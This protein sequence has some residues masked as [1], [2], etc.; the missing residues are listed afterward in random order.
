MARLDRLAPVR[1][2]AQIGAC[3]GREF[4]HE[5]LAAVAPMTGNVLTDALQQLIGS[6]LIFAVGTPPE[7]TYRFK[8]ALVQDTA[9]ESLLRRRRCELNLKI[10]ETL[11]N[12]EGTEPAI[13]AAHYTK[14]EMPNLAVP[15]WLEAGQ[16]AQA[17]AQYAES[18]AHVEAGLA[19][20][21]G[22]GSNDEKLVLEI[23]LHTCLALNYV[24]TRGYGSPEAEVSY[25]RAEALLPE[26]E[27]DRIALPVLL[28]VGIFWWLRADFPL[29][30]KYFQDLRQRA[31][32]VD[33]D[34]MVFAARAEI[35]S[36]QLYIGAPA[37]ARKLIA[38]VLR[39]YDPATHGKLSSFAMQDYAVLTAGFGAWTEN[40][41]G[42]FDSARALAGRS[43]AIARESRHA[44]SLGMALSTAACAAIERKE[45]AAAV[46]L[47]E[48]CIDLCQEQG[49][50]FW[51]DYAR[52]AQGLALALEGRPKE[53]VEL[54]GNSIEALEI[55]GSLQSRPTLGVYWA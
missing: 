40:Y 47:A 54:I 6:E 33:D 10:A 1:E 53:G 23:S 16:K 43:V 31:Q 19:L 24:T 36:V 14:A 34:L 29:S 5:L 51:A 32:H 49:L 8:H 15:K 37:A 27:D 13:L 7:A 38:D 50:P 11:A 35:A 48:Q 4:S 25:R 44:F 45:T 28:G 2:V 52:A 39:D 18:I 55:L 9:Y 41:L 30:L 12:I 3:I 42:Y 20:L 46:A 17:A 21:D 22:L 26:V